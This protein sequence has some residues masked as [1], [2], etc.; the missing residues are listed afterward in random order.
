MSGGSARSTR[1]IAG[2]ESTRET[3]CE[4]TRT[5][6]WETAPTEAMQAL[7]Q[8]ATP[9]VSSGQQGHGSDESS[10]IMSA[11]CGPDVADIIDANA[12][13]TGADSSS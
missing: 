3:D 12:L 6:G 5:M 10:G 4:E 2:G 13:A 1:G 11:Q 7:R 9:L 8:A